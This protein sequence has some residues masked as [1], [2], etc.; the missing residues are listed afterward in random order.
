[1]GTPSTMLELGTSAPDFSLPDWGADGK[2]V[3]RQDFRDAAGLLVIFMCNH[4]PYVHH[5]RKFLA[6]FAKEY[7]PK[8][9][10]IVGIN[11]NDISSYPE[12]SPDNMTKEVENFGYTFPY[13]FDETQEI[14]KAYRAACTPDFFLFDSEHKLVYRGQF[15]DSRPKNDLPVTGLDLRTAVDALLSGEIIDPNQKASLGCNIKWKLGNEPDYFRSIQLKPSKELAE[16]E[17]EAFQKWFQLWGLNA[18]QET[19][20]K[21]GPI[22]LEDK[23]LEKISEYMCAHIGDRLSDRLAGKSPTKLSEAQETELRERMA[24]MEEELE[25]QRESIDQGFERTEKRL[26]QIEKRINQTDKHAGQIE[27]RIEGI[28]THFKT[29]NQRIDRLTIRFGIAL[30]V[31]AILIIILGIR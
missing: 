8:G 28:D 31:I 9:L 23:Q 26:E 19:L 16:S 24:K 4:C 1:M 2:L 14:A 12:D 15:D 17:T 5:I 3:S 11:A 29:L 10:A 7:Q 6:D 21:V 13:L 27:K 30:G 22:S 25:H 20:D 18:N